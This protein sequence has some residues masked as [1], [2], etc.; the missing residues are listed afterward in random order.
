MH[1]LIDAE[2]SAVASRPR[3]CSKDCTTPPPPPAVAQKRRFQCKEGKVA[4]WPVPPKTPVAQSER[5]RTAL[6][7]HMGQAHTLGPHNALLAAVGGGV[8]LAK[9]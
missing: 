2:D 3:V 8:H 9:T 6:G 7:T 5:R 1:G 4:D